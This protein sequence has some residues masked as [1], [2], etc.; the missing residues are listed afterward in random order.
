MDKKKGFKP[1]RNVNDLTSVLAGLLTKQKVLVQI[2]A[3]NL[4]FSTSVTK[5]HIDF[6]RMYSWFKKKSQLVDVNYYTA[7]D[8]EDTKQKGFLD[9]LIIFGYKLITKP[10]K[11]YDTGIKGNMDIELA[12][13]ALNKI[14]DY[15]VLVLFSGDGD[16]T[17]LIQDI[18]KKGKRIIVIG[19]GGFTSYE[20]H[21]QAH[22]Y[23]FLNR[24]SSIW[25]KQR[26]PKKSAEPEEELNIS[27]QPQVFMD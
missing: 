20:L 7:F 18:E 26:K 10:I 14:D 27:D 1:P 25:Q 24:I 3:A 21:Q 5:I 22:N 19:T 9:D 15:D 4:F 11:V 16:F 8:P 17:Y 23:F 12:V 2:D 13:D 6:E